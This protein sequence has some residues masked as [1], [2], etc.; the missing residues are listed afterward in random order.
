MMS[1]IIYSRSGE[2]NHENGYF[3]RQQFIKTCENVYKSIL[4]AIGLILSGSL[5]RLSLMINR[6]QLSR[7]FGD[8]NVS[9]MP[10]IR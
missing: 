2:D 6:F 7:R 1:R 9:S 5:Y 3:T 10:F 8:G 4:R